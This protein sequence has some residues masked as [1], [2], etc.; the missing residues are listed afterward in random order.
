MRV[1][2]SVF[3]V[4]TVGHHLKFDILRTY[5]I[6]TLRPYPFKYQRQ[7]PPPLQVE[8][9]AGAVAG[10]VLAMGPRRALPSA[11]FKF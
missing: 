8:V 1:T 5:K 7:P 11:V 3:L 2:L 6:A 9:S 10:A 4:H